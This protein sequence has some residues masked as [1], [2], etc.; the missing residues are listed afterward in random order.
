MNGIDKNDL[1][2]V[3]STTYKEL[4]TAIRNYTVSSMEVYSLTLRALVELRQ[5]V[6]AEER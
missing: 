2:E 3:I 4:K 6:V 1:D 5:Q